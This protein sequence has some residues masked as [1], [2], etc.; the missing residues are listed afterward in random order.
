MSDKRISESGA[1]FKYRDFESSR[2]LL[3]FLSNN[4]E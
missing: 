4:V 3:T 1:K 2:Q